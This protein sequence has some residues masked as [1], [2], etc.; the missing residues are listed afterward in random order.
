MVLR[1]RNDRGPCGADLAGPIT[2]NRPPGGLFGASCERRARTPW[3]PGCAIALRLTTRCCAPSPSGLPDCI[4]TGS[5][6]AARAGIRHST[7]RLRGDRIARPRQS[8]R[9]SGHLEQRDTITLE[10]L[11]HPQG[12]SHLTRLNNLKRSFVPTP[13]RTTGA[14][15]GAPMVD[16][17][18]RCQLGPAPTLGSKVG[19]AG[20]RVGPFHHIQGLIVRPCARR[21]GV[22][23]IASGLQAQLWPQPAV[24]RPDSLWRGRARVV[25][26]T[27]GSGVP[28]SIGVG[29]WVLPQIP[30][31][32][33]CAT[34]HT[35][36]ERAAWPRRVR[37]A[38][39][40]HGG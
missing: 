6:T 32:R 7:R 4:D 34:W 25:V 19:I 30:C 10:W 15:T 2:E 12:H 5:G 1:Y 13:G 29:S 33:R 27:G 24:A 31:C 9:P 11:R 39:G 17:H 21:S 16:I 18:L 3:A 37:P 8:G 28:M 36:R 26:G 22:A 14:S 40:L 38:I 35:E 20:Q 23:L